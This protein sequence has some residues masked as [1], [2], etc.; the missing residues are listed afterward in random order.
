MDIKHHNEIIDI[1]DLN[2]L[3]CD[4]YPIQLDEIIKAQHKKG[5]GC[6]FNFFAE[7]LDNNLFF[8]MRTKSCLTDEDLKYELREKYKLLLQISYNRGIRLEI[9][10]ITVN[11]QK[12]DNI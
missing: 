2:I 12:V 9:K 11:T 10:K 6:Y 8:C 5:F 3:V 4:H 7:S 1:Q